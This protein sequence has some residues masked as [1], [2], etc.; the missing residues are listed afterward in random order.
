MFEVLFWLY[1]INAIMIICHEIDSAYWKEWELFR[2]PGGITLFLILHIP[3]LFFILYGLI[4][5]FTKTSGGLTV[6][7]I[8]SGGGL[9]AFI[10]H[11][12]FFKKGR[13]EFRNPISIL[14]LVA[15]AI[16]SMAQAALSVYIM[17]E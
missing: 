7:L 15:I 13:D 3:I 12:Y 16:I 5:V 4:L 9:L 1:L 8:V 10:I 17:L 6:S 2:L 11:S 14:I